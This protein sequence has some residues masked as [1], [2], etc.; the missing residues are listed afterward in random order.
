MDFVVIGMGRGK[1]GAT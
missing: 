1:L